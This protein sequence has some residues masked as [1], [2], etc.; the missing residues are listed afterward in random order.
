MRGL[1]DARLGCGVTSTTAVPLAMHGTAAVSAGP[2]GNATSTTAMVRSGRFF[3]LAVARGV[4]RPDPA[5]SPLQAAARDL[6]RP[7]LAASS[8]SGV[9]PQV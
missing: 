6:W 8:P 1:G 7:D 4:S 2:G 5:T 3:S 9:G